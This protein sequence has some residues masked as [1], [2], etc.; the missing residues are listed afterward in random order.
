MTS[1]GVARAYR[2]PRS[3]L[4]VG[5]IFPKSGAGRNKYG[6]SSEQHET[7]GGTPNRIGGGSKS[8]AYVQN[9]AVFSDSTWKF[10]DSTDGLRN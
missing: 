3:P 5:P 4:R 9:R 2:D 7:C 1:N 10:A 8:G 6:K